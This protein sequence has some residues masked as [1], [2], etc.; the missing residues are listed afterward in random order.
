MNENIKNIKDLLKGYTIET[1]PSVY[2]KIDGLKNLLPKKTWV[3]ITYLPD[4]HPKNIIEPAK[5]IKEEGLEPIPHL[6]A[7][8]IQS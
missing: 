3:Y 1:P 5:K 6:P 2:K 4:E 8:T 7:R